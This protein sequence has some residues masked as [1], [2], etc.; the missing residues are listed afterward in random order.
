[1]V[2]P[3]NG[4]LGLAVIVVSAIVVVGGSVVGAFVVG[5]SVAGGV[6]LVVLDT[7]GDGAVS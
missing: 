2:T 4:L 7:V 3:S 1:M 5:G 6:V